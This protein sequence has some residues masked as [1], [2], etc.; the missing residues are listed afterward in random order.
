LATAQTYVQAF[1]E[2]TNLLSPDDQKNPLKY[3]DCAGKAD[4][5]T[6]SLFGAFLG[7]DG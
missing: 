3:I 4:P 2:C 1:T 5:S 6:K 7:S